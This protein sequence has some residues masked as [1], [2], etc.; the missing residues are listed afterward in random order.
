[1]MKFILTQEVDGLGSPGDVVEAELR[2]EG[3]VGRGALRAVV[4][5]GPDRVE[6]A[7]AHYAAPDRCGGCQWQHLGLDAQREAKRRI[8]A[9]AFARI[10]RQPV[11]PPPIVGGAPWRYRRTLTLALRRDGARS[12]AGLRAYDDPEAVFALEDCLITDERVVA[13]WRTVLAARQFL[14]DAAR[15]R[16]TIRWLDDRAAFVLEGGTEWPALADFLAAV[17]ALGAIWWQAE[18]KRRRLVADRR[19]SEVP[20]ASFTQVNA[21]VAALLHADVVATVLAHAPAYVVDAYSGGG[22]TAVALQVTGVRVAAVE[23]DEEATAWSARR[24]PAPSRAIASRVEDALPH[25]LPADVVVLNPPRAGVDARVAQAL[26][27]APPRAI[28][29]VSCDPAT[30]AR[31]VGRLVGWRVRSLRCYDMFP[32]TAHVE[33]LCE[34]VP[35][36]T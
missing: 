15:L 33:T 22:D 11:P 12:W 1:M 30:L 7:C 34:L 10:A 13:A 9:D 24:L 31:D 2:V 23:L 28:V 18:G 3:R 8:V 20:G 36:T 17:P 32:Q 19:P 29:Y 27:A 16:G 21:E 14:P 35:E 5:P 4:T 25:L 6:P 26:R